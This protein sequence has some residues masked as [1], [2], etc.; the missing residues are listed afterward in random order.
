MFCPNCGRDCGEFKFCPECGQELE[1]KTKK[2]SFED[3]KKRLQAEGQVYCPDCLSTSYTANKERRRTIYYRSVIASLL[4]LID[5][6]TSIYFER[7]KGIQCTCLQCGRWW[8]PKIEAVRECYRK[9]VEGLLSG[10]SAMRFTGIDEGFLELNEDQVV[11]C[12]SGQE[13]M[14]IPYEKLAKIDHR[15]CLGPAYGRLTIRDLKHKTRSLPKT[16][17]AA[18]KDRFTILYAPDCAEGYRKVYALLRQI[19]EE[20]KKAK[21][22]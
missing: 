18:K 1:E 11:I 10:Y 19:V 4:Q 6:V 21:L 7:R 14:V 20:N 8:F 5:T 22:V 3:K 12:H 2:Q 15:E 9:Q 13:K 16:F 17:N